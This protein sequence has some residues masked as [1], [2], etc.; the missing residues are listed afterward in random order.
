MK[1]EN[2]FT[3]LPLAVML[4]G[5]AFVLIGC[6]DNDDETD[7]VMVSY[8]ITVDNLSNGQPLTPLAVVLHE[9]GYL[10][11]S[12]GEVV[13]VGM[14]MLAEGGDPSAFL[15]E[16]ADHAEVRLTA[17]SSNGPFGPGASESVTISVEENAALQMS[18]ASMLANTNDAYTGVSG[19]VIGDLAAGETR[20]VLAPALDAGTEE[21]SEAMGS[22]PGPADSG[23]GFNAV[24]ESNS[25]VTVH[26]G[27]LSLDDG[28]STSVLTEAHRWLN[29]VSRIQ[30]E[31]IQ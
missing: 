16:A 11:W 23:E 18:L 24:R 7:P 25:V 28:L 21:N 2:L 30:V 27:V 22:I 8:R 9:N 6:S 19:L 13:T 1:T 20:I 4:L 26:P 14:E 5:L 17:A 29:P 31:R 10:P 12:E 3:R 15:A